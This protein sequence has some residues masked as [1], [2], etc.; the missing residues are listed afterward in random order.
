MKGKGAAK[1]PHYSGL[2]KVMTVGEVAAYLRVSR[3]T[4]QRLLRSHQI[5]AF[6]VGGDWRF[7]LEQIDRWISQQ[8]HPHR[9]R[10]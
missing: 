4:I 5:P 9:M 6:R 2:V 10:E 7:T 8:H 3:S 1:T